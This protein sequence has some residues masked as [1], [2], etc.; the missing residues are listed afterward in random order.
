MGCPLSFGTAIWT[1]LPIRPEPYRE[2]Q[3]KGSGLSLSQ[4]RTTDPFCADPL[5]HPGCDA[6]LLLADSVRVD[7][8][9]GKL[10]MA[11]PLL[12]HVEGNAPANGLHAEAVP[13]AL[14]TGVGAIRDARR[15]DDLL[16]APERCH[17]A[18]WP[19][20]HLR[21]PTPLSLTEAVHHIKRVQQI[22]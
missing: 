3:P 13:Q 5:P 2:P 15:G 20:Q 22:G 6:L 10:G 7:R 1:E 14:G 21:L 12:H 17:A 16:H 18:P 8:R 11:E 4:P 19:K 9:R